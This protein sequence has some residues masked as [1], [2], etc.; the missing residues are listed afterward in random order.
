MDVFIAGLGVLGPGLEGWPEARSVL[1]GEQAHEERELVLSPP[2]ILSG[3]ERR[4]SSSTTRL[5]LNAALEAVTQ[6]GIAA[7]DLAAV[8]GSSNG[9][10]LETHQIL[11]A[12][13]EADMPVSPTQFHNSVHNSAVGYWCIAT[14]CHRASTSIA[15]HDFTFAAALLKAAAQVCSEK[16]PLL[17]TVSD[18]PLPAPLDEKRPIAAPFAVALVLTPRQ[19]KGSISRLSLTWRKGAEDAEEERL[20]ATESLE[21]LW[22]GNPAGRALPLFQAFALEKPS[23]LLLAYPESGRLEIEASPC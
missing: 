8:F 11:V 2:D 7:Q 17:L 1:R 10:G 20:A 9:S 15:S 21:R 22:R 19:D 16:I 13:T 14:G 6:S 12:L 5:A 23:K 4:R 3:R 18:C